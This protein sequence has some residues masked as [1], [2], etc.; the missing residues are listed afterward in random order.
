[1]IARMMRI[2]RQRLHCERL[3]QNMG[4]P[5][6]QERFEQ[7]PELM[8]Q[9]QFFTLLVEQFARVSSGLQSISQI[10]QAHE[11]G[12]VPDVPF[13]ADMKSDPARVGNPAVL[14][15]KTL[16]QESIANWTRKRYINNAAGVHVADL[17]ASETE[18]S[19]TKAVRMNRYVLPRGN[20]LFQPLQMLHIPPRRS[21]LRC[22]RMVGRFT[23][24]AAD[25]GGQRS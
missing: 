5:C 21:F 14:L 10:G 6:R 2:V 23:C 16:G 18:F 17:C 24:H 12:R 15:G 19:A 4:C 13:A 7:R 20:F 9:M 25:C 8:S 1:M 11:P 22:P 3:G